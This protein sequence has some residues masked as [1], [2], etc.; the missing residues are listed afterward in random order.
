MTIQSSSARD[1]LAKTNPEQTLYSHTNQVINTL[2]R[3]F[4]NLPPQVQ[5]IDGLL[6]AAIITALFHDVGKAH[7]EFQNML[8]GLHDTW[9]HRRHEIISSSLFAIQLE[10]N[11]SENDL[12]KA[13]VGWLAP[14]W[15]VILLHHKNLNT[16]L[17]ERSSAFLEPTHLER[18]PFS[19]GNV[20]FIKG[21]FEKWCINKNAVQDMMS[22]LAPTIERVSEGLIHGSNEYALPSHFAISS[23]LERYLGKP[24]LPNEILDDPAIAFGSPWL[25]LLRSGYQHEILSV[26]QT[27]FKT[28]MLLGLLKTSDHM[29]SGNYEPVEIPS[30]SMIKFEK[31]LRP[32]QKRA[33]QVQGSVILRAPT[34]SGKT[35]AAIAW[36]QTNQVKNGRMVYVLPFQASL[37][38]MY[39]RIYAMMHSSKNDTPL[40]GISHSK[41]LEFL[42]SF[43]ENTDYTAE[44][45]LFDVKALRDLAREVYFPVKV[46]TAHQLLRF[47]LFGKGWETLLLELSGA[48]IVFDEIHAYEP[49]ILGFIVGMMKIL[50]KYLNA[51]FIIMTA[52]LPRFI[53]KLINDE[54][55]SDAPTLNISLDPQQAEDA[56]ILN[57]KRHNL[58]TFKSDI[59][60][61][62][63]DEKN[64]QTILSRYDTCLTQ[65][66]VC[67]TVGTAQ[68]LYDFFKNNTRFDKKHLLLLH[69]RFNSLDRLEKERLM[70]IPPIKPDKETRDEHP[71]N[72]IRVLIATQVVEVSLNISYNYGYFEIAPI[73]ALIQRMG[74]INRQGDSPVN[75]EKESNVTI[76]LKGIH[77][78][79]IYNQDIIGLTRLELEKIKEKS[80]SEMDWQEIVDR[81]YPG[82]SK[83][84]LEEYERGSKHDVI[85]R[86]ESKFEVGF[87]QE[88]V[89]ELVENADRHIE[90]IP[91]ESFPEFERLWKEKQFL[92]AR[93]LFVSADIR[94]F[95]GELN[96]ER[97]YIKQYHAYILKS[98]K[99]AY[100]SEYG[101][102]YI[103]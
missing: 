60:S 23:F 28:A 69:S 20:K 56:K 26:F 82:F 89:A 88:W 103:R 37:N 47:I 75:I 42:S 24:S 30:F 81:V 90:I 35:E 83:V 78:G 59:F 100:S 98:E 101:L 49:R 57:R 22:G 2:V 29:A 91:K 38:A 62:L 74:R 34:G 54:V 48:T 63:H 50:K 51:K 10:N 5:N 77:D 21:D 97:D 65:L 68:E 99:F 58:E 3:V 13:I 36:V 1:I 70:K 15:L 71:A 7:P 86:Y 17:S 43:F 96:F 45:A 6:D 16:G 67:N 61:F 92:E 12:K 55:F 4:E 31:E 73:D 44:D 95:R 76:F 64:F 72:E 18:I 9:Q 84:D 85:V 39:E 102:K 40:V 94:I 11:A 32:F 53:I 52:T 93:R 46:S 27:R 8:R 87:Q 80:I 79:S 14:I 66:F 33:S 25:A 19:E 41:N